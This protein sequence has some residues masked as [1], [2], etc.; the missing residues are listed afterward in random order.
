MVHH[1]S[2]LVERLWLTHGVAI[3]CADLVS[4]QVLVWLPAGSVKEGEACHEATCFGLRSGASGH[5]SI[6]DCS[7]SGLF[8]SLIWLCPILWL[9]ETEAG[10][11]GPARVVEVGSGLSYCRAAVLMTCSGSL[12]VKVVLISK[13]PRQQ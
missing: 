3:A 10:G 8:S 2:L 11:R 12:G 13:E 1:Q 7:F 5:S 4:V 9:S 6:K